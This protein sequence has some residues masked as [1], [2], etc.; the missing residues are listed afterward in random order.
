MITSEL[1]KD[2]RFNCLLDLLLYSYFLLSGG[3]ITHMLTGYEIQ[4]SNSIIIIIGLNADNALNS[5]TSL[6]STIIFIIF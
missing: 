4:I 6:E 3:D 5:C 2:L 1:M